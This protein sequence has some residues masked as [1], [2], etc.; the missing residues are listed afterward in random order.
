M[1]LMLTVLRPATAPLR[2]GEREVS[3]AARLSPRRLTFE[4]FV[5]VLAAGA[6]SCF[7]SAGSPAAAL[8]V[9]WPASTRCWRPCRCSS[10]WQS[11]S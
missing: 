4:A 6:P 11:V 2:E 10:V 3:T 1:V 8:P 5:V 9:R 7:A